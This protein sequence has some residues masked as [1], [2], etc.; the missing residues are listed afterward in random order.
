MRRIPREF[1]EDSTFAISRCGPCRFRELQKRARAKKEGIKY[2][3]SSLLERGCERHKFEAASKRSGRKAEA[4][5][6]FRHDM[7]EK[8]GFLQG[9]GL[10][11]ID[12]PPKVDPNAKRARTSQRDSRRSVLRDRRG[13]G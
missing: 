10:K 5:Q 1:Q 7:L 11:P 3:N 9:Q 2:A 12:A 4:H 6:F 8:S 13:Y